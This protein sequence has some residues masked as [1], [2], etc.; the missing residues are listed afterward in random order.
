MKHNKLFFSIF[1]IIIFLFVISINFVSYSSGPNEDWALIVFYG[2]EEDYYIYDDG[3]IN[4]SALEGVTYDKGTNTLTLSNLKTSNRLIVEE[5]GD[6]FKINL[7]G[8]NEVAYVDCRSDYDFGCNLHFTGYGSLT[9]NKDRNSSRA[10]VV[11]NGKIIVDDSVT[12]K[13]YVP[14]SIEGWDN[15]NPSVLYVRNTDENDEGS[16]IL[17]NGDKLTIDNSRMYDDIL[18]EVKGLGFLENL[19]EHPAKY[20]IFEKNGEKY[21]M[22][23]FGD[24]SYRIK[25]GHVK[26]EEVNG[27][28]FIDF[29]AAEHD[30]AYNTPEELE[31]AGYIDVDEEFSTDKFLIYPYDKSKGGKFKLVKDKDNV[32]HAVYYYTYYSYV[33]SYAYDFTD[34][35]ITLDNGETYT[36][37]K[38]NKEI[39]LDDLTDVTRRE[40]WDEYEHRVS[41]ATLIILPTNIEITE[42]ANQTYILGGNGMSFRIATDYSNFENG[43]KVF[44]DDNETN[45][46][47]SKSGSTIIEFSDK[48]LSTLNEGEHTF[49]VNFNNGTYATTKF[50]IA[51]ATILPEEHTLTEETAIEETAIEETNTQT[52]IDSLSSTNPKTGDNIKIWFVLGIIST[53]SMIGTA[54]LK[55]HK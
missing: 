44:V 22:Y 49:K 28:T 18:E 39:N 5:M 31:A 20:K 24:G 13:L 33:L 41:S 21:A 2:D 36:I 42:G 38:R 55:K 53:I 45:E 14:E 23:R 9:A 54:I 32:E 52:K 29:S 16:I 10:I 43:G 40:Y 15:Y 3:D 17:K 48:Y 30:E 19:N 25:A 4:N 35:N 46:F 12:L 27:E 50:N 51:K 37:L 8:D 34:K 6:D 11:F 1:F 7:I 26:Y 47:S